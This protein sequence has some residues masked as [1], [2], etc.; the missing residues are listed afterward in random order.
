MKFPVLQSE[1]KTNSE[2]VFQFHCDPI[3]NNVFERQSANFSSVCSE[4]LINLKNS[5]KNQGN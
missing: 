3:H 4:L 2:I 5:S 1:K